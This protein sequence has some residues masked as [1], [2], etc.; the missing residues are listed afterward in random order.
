MIEF[1]LDT[2]SLEEEIGHAIPVSFHSSFYFVHKK[3]KRWILRH[4]L[5]FDDSVVND[6]ILFYSL[7]K[8]KYL[9]Q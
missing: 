8:K 3:L 6:L 4:P 1:R 5:A 2:C 7:A 9:D